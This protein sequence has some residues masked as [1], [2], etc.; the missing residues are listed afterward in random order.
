MKPKD[1]FKCIDVKDKIRRETNYRRKIQI[2]S[3]EKVF[4]K[5]IFRLFPDLYIHDIKLELDKDSGRREITLYF[6]TYKERGVAIG[7]GGS[8]IR[9]INELIE[10]YIMFE[11][12]KKPIEIKCKA[13]K[14]E[15]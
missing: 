5:L 2:I 7:R 6:L 10:R 15:I 11:N 9:I 14:A 12:D 13:I 1:Y 8:Y 4:I 3:E